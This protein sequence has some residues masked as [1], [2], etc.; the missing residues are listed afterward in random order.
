MNKSR[1]P[2]GLCSN[3][4]YQFKCNGCD[5]TYI[6]E[7]A[8][9]LC[10][11]EHNRIGSGSNIADHVKK[12][13]CNTNVDVSNFEILSNQFKNYWERVLYEALMIRFHSPTINVQ[14]TLSTK[15]LRV[16]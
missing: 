15:L 8:R 14:T 9:H 4:V 12:N 13:K 11:K 3:I 6:G 1:T 10:T 5:A 2:I 16:F 7:T